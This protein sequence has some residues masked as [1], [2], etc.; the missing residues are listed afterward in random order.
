MEVM[1]GIQN[2]Y[3]Q[4]KDLQASFHQTTVIPV[5]DRVKEA[6]GTLYL[7]VPGKMR[8]E[9]TKGPHRIVLIDGRQLWF[10]DPQEGQLTITDLSKIPNS[11]YLLAFLTGMGELKEVFQPELSKGVVKTATGH[12]KIYLRPRAEDSQWKSLRITV[13]PKTFQVIETAFEGIQGD[14]NIIRYYNIKVNVGL[15]DEIFRLEVPPGTEILHYP[16]LQ[17]G[18]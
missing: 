9:Y 13:D 8:W 18:G 12:L 1:E 2:R 15:E 10:Y 7:K 16:P 5:M 11:D 17:E 14:R 4:I 6:S 3:R